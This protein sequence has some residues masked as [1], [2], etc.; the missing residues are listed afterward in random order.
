MIK[1]SELRERLK[2]FT[3]V[4][5]RKH[6]WNAYAIDAIL[7]FIQ[8]IEDEQAKK[9]NSVISYEKRETRSRL[10]EIEKEQRKNKRIT[11]ED[12]DKNLK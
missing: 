9:G 8:F 12:D 6:W 3:E 2:D 4:S 5:G 10:K 1:I 7:K 11:P